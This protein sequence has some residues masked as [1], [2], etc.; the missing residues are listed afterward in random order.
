MKCL[1]P[2]P[3]SSSG[4]IMSFIRTIPLFSEQPAYTQPSLEFLKED[5]SPYGKIS[6]WVPMVIL[7]E[8]MTERLS[9]MISIGLLI[10]VDL[11]LTIDICVQSWTLGV[12]P[13]SLLRMS[14][15]GGS[16]TMKQHYV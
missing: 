6:N 12:F 1:L 15:S 16:D 9:L 11:L 13:W 2:T 3:F 10:I 4:R 7:T 5:F 8:S 14:S